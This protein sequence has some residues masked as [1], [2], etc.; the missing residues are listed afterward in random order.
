MMATSERP[1]SAQPAFPVHLPLSL[2]ATSRVSG[3]GD[4]I[5]NEK[6][7][8]KLRV[9]N[10]VGREEFD[11]QRCVLLRTLERLTELELELAMLKRRLQGGA[12]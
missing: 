7:K 1:A 6:L 9:L 10:L 4:D 8:A 3:R 11:I 5:R 12:D 2:D